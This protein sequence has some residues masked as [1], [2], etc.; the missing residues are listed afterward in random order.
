MRV[1]IN[2]RVPASDNVALATDVYLPDGPGPFPVIFTRIPY[3][4]RS[5]TGPA[6]R[7]IDSGYA[8]VL[9]DTRGRFDSDGVPCP[10]DERE[11]GRSNDR[12]KFYRRLPHLSRLRQFTGGGILSRLLR[13]SRDR[14]TA[15]GPRPKR[16]PDMKKAPPDFAEGC[17]EAFLLPIGGTPRKRRN[18]GYPCP[19][20]QFAMP[21]GVELS[22]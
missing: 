10:P 7:S 9:Q 14:S 16:T 1:L 4:R 20:Q 12:D 13:A 3:D 5:K 21:E 18:D 11:D 19:L 22:G 17:R 2:Q 6:P 15:Q 8:L